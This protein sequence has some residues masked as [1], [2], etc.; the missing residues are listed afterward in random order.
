VVEREKIGL[1]GRPD[2]CAACHRRSANSDPLR[3]AHRCAAPHHRSRSDI[4][5]RRSTATGKR[6]AALRTFRRLGLASERRGAGIHES[7]RSACAAGLSIAGRREWA[8]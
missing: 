5:R 4:G 1:R 7:A 3:Q 2:A 6:N 8:Q